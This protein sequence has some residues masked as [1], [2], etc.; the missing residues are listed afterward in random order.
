M[1]IIQLLN[2]KERGNK[3][4]LSHIANFLTIVSPNLEQINKTKN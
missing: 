3:G 4:I 2:G 1:N